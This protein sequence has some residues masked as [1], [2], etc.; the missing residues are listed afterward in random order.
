MISATN[1][2][3]HFSD[4][5]ADSD[6]E[7]DTEYSANDYRA[8]AIMFLSIVQPAIAHVLSAKNQK[9]GYCQIMFALGLDDRSMRDAAADLCVDVKCISDGAKRFVK[10]NSL[11]IPSCMKSEEACKAYSKS[12]NKRLTA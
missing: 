4:E 10:E 12:R 1:D 7:G 9:I 8:C 6:F 11:P 3:G 5:E 2:D